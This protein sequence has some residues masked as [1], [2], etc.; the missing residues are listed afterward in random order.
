MTPCPLRLAP[1]TDLR[2]HLDTHAFTDGQRS[3]FVIAGLGSLHDAQLRLAGSASPVTVAGPSEL[4]AITGSLSADGAHLHVVLADAE[5]RVLGG[6]LCHGSLV[7]T[8]AELLLV[9]VPGYQL[10][11][12]PDPATGERELVVTPHPAARP[13]QG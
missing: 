4:L 2:R 1:G 11:R 10:A 7:R 12:A 3:G 8:T 5:G 9:P 13:A 6:H